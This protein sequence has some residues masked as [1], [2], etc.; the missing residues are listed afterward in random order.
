MASIPG[1]HFP[2]IFPNNTT[3][4]VLTMEFVNRVKIT[5]TEAISAAG[6]GRETMA[7]VTFQALL[8]NN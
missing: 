4:R 5:N 1:V 6:L 7:E 3:T 8:N 2:E